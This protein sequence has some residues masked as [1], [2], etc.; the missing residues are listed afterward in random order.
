MKFEW[1]P[2]KAKSNLEKHK[3]T[4]EE[5]ASCFNDTNSVRIRSDRPPFAEVRFLLI[6]VS[7]NMRVLSVA[8]TE[9]AGKIRIISVR[10]ASREERERY[11]E[12]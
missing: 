3:V 11:E 4:F 12:L 1:N 2:N 7:M 5:G 9:R 6:A 8:Y 10:K